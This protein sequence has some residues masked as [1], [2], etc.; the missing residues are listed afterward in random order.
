MFSPENGR[1]KNPRRWNYQAENW[2][3]KKTKPSTQSRNQLKIDCKQPLS[4]TWKNLMWSIDRKTVINLLFNAFS[5]L[6]NAGTDG[7]AWQF[8]EW[9][10]IKEHFKPLTRIL[11]SLVS[12]LHP[13]HSIHLLRLRASR[14][15]SQTFVIRERI[16]LRS[17][18]TP[19]YDLIKKSDHLSI[20][21]HR[22]SWL[23]K[24]V[25]KRY[26]MAG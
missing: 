20:H 24:T 7:S 16:G 13:F 12:P 22:V 25:G 18:E 26:R 2:Q 4:S 23:F 9:K 6:M 17:L 3:T 8:P 10:K 14:K 11:E 21:F 19:L 1:K 5:E 15:F